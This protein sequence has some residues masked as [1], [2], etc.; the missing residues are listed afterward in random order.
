MN[1]V[2]LIFCIFIEIVLGLCIGL[3]GAVLKRRQVLQITCDEVI[4]TPIP[5]PLC[6]SGEE[7]ENSAAKLSLGKRER[8]R[9]GLKD[10]AFISHYPTSIW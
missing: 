3:W 7:G 1:V 9:K 5:H 2:G 10:V 4:I 6:H 8:W